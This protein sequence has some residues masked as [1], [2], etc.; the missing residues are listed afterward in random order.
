MPPVVLQ[1]DVDYFYAQYEEISNPSL[2]D[3]PVAIRQ[4]HIVVTCNYIA[5]S[6]G[7][8]KLALLSD[9]LLSCPDLIVIDGS[10]ISRYRQASREIYNL[11]QSILYVNSKTG[12][13]N[14]PE[15]PIQRQGMDEVFIDVG[16]YIEHRWSQSLTDVASITLPCGTSLPLRNDIAKGHVIGDFQRT[17]DARSETPDFRAVLGV[18][19]AIAYFLREVIHTKLGYTTSAGISFNKL[20]AKLA[21]GENKPNDQTTILAGQSADL[22]LQRQY[23]RRVPG[24]GREVRKKILTHFAE[25][26][27]EINP[28]VGIVRTLLPLRELT[29]MFGRDLGIKIYELLHGVDR[30]EVVAS[31]MSKQISVEDSFLVCDDSKDATA[32]MT[33]LAVLLLERM[34]SE[35]WSAEHGWRRFARQLRLTIRQ[36]GERQTSRQRE[37]RTIRMPVDVYDTSI[38][39][40]DRALTVTNDKLV[41][42]LQQ[43]TGKHQSLHLT[44]IN[45]AAVNFHSE[46]EGESI[47]GMLGLRG[48]PANEYKDG[49]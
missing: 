8:Q 5:R 40:P 2:R 3:L 28:T 17:G 7:V 4:K 6:R 38:T 21:A 44:L 42:L 24:I 23:L 48:G 49:Q 13:T 35:E 20:F 27:V 45:I 10:D 37:S 19:N 26:S 33:Q 39:L 25:H 12:E 9:A 30:S 11:V 43:M 34:Q 14:A 1:I 41:P 18:G 32:R 22:F 15:I 29:A 31:G 16:A 36:R 47:I 46:A